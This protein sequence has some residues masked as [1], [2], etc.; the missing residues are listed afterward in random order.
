MSDTPI[1]NAL[2]EHL[3]ENPGDIDALVDALAKIEE[4]AGEHQSNLQDAV[5]EWPA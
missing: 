3:S 4:L 5:P 1:T 2:R